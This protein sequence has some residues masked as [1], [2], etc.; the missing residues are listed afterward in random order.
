M[1]T[2]ALAK[3]FPAQLAGLFAAFAGM[4]AGSLMPQKLRNRHEHV[5]HV[6]GM[7]ATR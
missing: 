1:T 2:T 6:Q 7:P 4:V 5:H 3:A